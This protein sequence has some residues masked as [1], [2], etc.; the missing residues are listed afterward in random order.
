[1]RL[2]SQA[3]SEVVVTAVKSATAHLVERIAALEQRNSDLVG[4]LGE[5]QGLRDRVVVIETKAAAPLPELPEPI[6]VTPLVE[7]LVVAEQTAKE[8]QG[9][10]ADALSLRDRV[11]AIE[12]K[13]VQ[14]VPEPPPAVD[15]APLAERLAVAEQ[16]VREVQGKLAES[17]SLR[18]RLVA[19]EVKSV[20]QSPSIDLTPVT[21]RLAAAEQAVKEVQGRVTAIEPRTPTRELWDGLTEQV[22][23]FRTRLSA[24]ETKEAPAAVDVTPLVERLVVAEQTVKELQGK[25]AEALALRD[26]VV[27]VE[28]KAAQP[29]PA[30]PPAVD[31]TPLTTRLAVAETRL[32][33]V[34][35]LEQGLRAAT[36]RIAA[37]EVKAAQ[38]LPTPPEPDL[39]PVLDRLNATEAHLSTLHDKLTAVEALQTKGQSPDV[40][41]LAAIR[42]DLKA[43]QPRPDGPDASTLTDFRERLLAVE[44]KAADDSVTRELGGLRERVAVL[45]VKAP[46]P[47]PAGRDGL[48]GRD[49]TDG[50]GFEDLSAEFDG[51]RTVSL[52]FQRGE[53]VKRFPIVLPFLKFQ[54]VF[55]QGHPYHAGDV[56]TWA[57]ASWHANE[58]TT[59]KPGESKAWTLMVKKGRDGRDVPVV[60]GAKG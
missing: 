22:V 44:R 14:P 9:K 2:D 23:D 52:K 48:N 26:R 17:L 59:E 58:P 16:T 15:L 24:I 50:V 20:P 7:R 13:S 49:G 47:G 33:H 55:Q 11:V 45:E 29:L 21:D 18:D 46:I 38:P 36:D 27:A 53:L 41:V 51:D 19:V 57:G 32:E 5:I 8:L 4:R 6:D 3:V 40:S 12:V 37:V 1:M 56:V 28:V 60:S 35:A 43:F 10:L 39:T 42:E 34:A 31:V 54:G 25:I 30:V